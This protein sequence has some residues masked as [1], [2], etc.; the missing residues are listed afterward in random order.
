M[1]LKLSTKSNINESLFGDNDF[2]QLKLGFEGGP[3]GLVYEK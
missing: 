2:N 3:I 1:L